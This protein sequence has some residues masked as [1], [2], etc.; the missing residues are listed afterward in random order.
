M[1]LIKKTFDT[2]KIKN[3]Q[4]YRIK[5]NDNYNYV[6]YVIRVDKKEML[7]ITDFFYKQGATELIAIS[8]GEISELTYLGHIENLVNFENVEEDLDNLDENVD[9]NLV[10]RLNFLF[11]KTMD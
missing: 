10:Q 7:L 9:F 11:N 2:E 3:G 5:T 1:S 4:L 8:P 6:G